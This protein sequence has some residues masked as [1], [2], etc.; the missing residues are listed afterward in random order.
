MNSCLLSLESSFRRLDL[1]L[2]SL[3]ALGFNLILITAAQRSVCLSSPPHAHTPIFT[4]AVAPMLL[5][6]F[7]FQTEYCLAPDPARHLTPV[8]SH[9]FEHKLGLG[10]WRS[11]T[12]WRPPLWSLQIPVQGSQ[13]LS[14]PWVPLTWDRQG[15]G[16]W[17]G[18][19]LASGAGRR[20]DLN[21][22]TAA[23][24]LVRTDKLAW[25]PRK[26]CQVPLGRQCDQM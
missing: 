23:G 22:N 19:S 7:F 4:S 8:Y 12:A 25:F 10:G 26:N 16:T 18:G 9:S 6:Q 1:Y 15:R 3:P 5:L 11:H 14:S 21:G 24:M 2:C 13:S 20:L 17:M